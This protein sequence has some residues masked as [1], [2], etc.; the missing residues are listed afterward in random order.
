MGRVLLC[1]GNYA[2]RPYYFDKAMV[3]LYSI[4]ELCYCLLTYACLLDQ[5]LIETRLVDWIE[6]ECGL[7]ELAESLRGYSRKNTTVAAFAKIILED[8]VYGS[9]EEI[10]RAIEEMEAGEHQSAY[11][12]KKLRGDCLIEARRYAAAILVY[13]AL[14]MELPERE[15]ELAARV[16]HNKG[17]AY[18]QLFLFE[19]AAESFQKAYEYDGA[20]ES[21]LQYLAASRFAM[22]ETEYVDFAARNVDS[23]ETTLQVEKLLEAVKE[24][25]EGSE[26]SRMLFTL[27][28]CK[29]EKNTVFYEKEM[30]SIIVKL[31]EEYR[32]IVSD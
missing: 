27:K 5:D 16:C 21:Y 17:V 24:Q 15:K 31:K 7:M 1:T 30:E 26:Q 22:G 18:A 3:N 23:Y 13:E 9:R 4:E 12:K 6:T 8:V 19:K 2:K 28:V 25:F 10:Q 14:L 20:E 29:E 11:E 32:Q